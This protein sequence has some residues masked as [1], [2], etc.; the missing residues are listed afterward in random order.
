MFKPIFTPNPHLIKQAAIV[1]DKVSNWL[2]PQQL[3]SDQSAMWIVD[4]FQY[5]IEH[6]DREEFFKRSQLIQ[7]TN[8]FFPGNVTSIEEKA[9]NIFQHC[10]RYAGLSHW[11]FKLNHSAMAIAPAALKADTQLVTRDSQNK[12]A[13]IETKNSQFTIGYNNQQTLKPEDLAASFAQLFA[14][15]MI[16]HAPQLPPQ[17]KTHLMEASEIISVFMGFGV[18]LANSA[19]TFRGGCGSCFNPSA[20]RHASLS[21]NEILFALAVFCCYKDI[22]TPE[23]T[24]HLKKHLR[25]PFS[26]ARKQAQ[27]VLAES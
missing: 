22:P 18:V 4:C 21:E 1:L 3:V 12:L 24:K 16:F 17:G 6:F 13:E 15:Y 5:A 26:T 11:P 25:R 20:N 10:I 14:Q 27:Q 7:P 23:A 2:R 9:D 19:Y 8:A